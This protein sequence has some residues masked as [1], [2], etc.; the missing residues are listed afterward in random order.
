[1][2]ESLQ[3]EPML[4]R[5]DERTALIYPWPQCGAEVENKN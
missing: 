4:G 2:L 1:M 3:S 5:T